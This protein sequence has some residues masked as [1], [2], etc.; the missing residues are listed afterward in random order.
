MKLY[1]PFFTTQK[2]NWQHKRVVTIFV[3]YFILRNESALFENS[4]NFIKLTFTGV[5]D[6][7]KLGSYEGKIKITSLWFINNNKKREQS[8]CTWNCMR[9]LLKG[10]TRKMF[11]HF[12]ISFSRSLLWSEVS[13]PNFVSQTNIIWNECA[14]TTKMTKSTQKPT[15]NRVYWDVAFF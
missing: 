3:S 15:K 13:V 8:H 7:S 4:T 14:W 10:Y 5:L 2:F 11:E 12:F 1:R 6:N 9:F